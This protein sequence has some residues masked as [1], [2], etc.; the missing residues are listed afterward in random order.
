MA[1]SSRKWKGS[2]SI[3]KDT[4]GGFQEEIGTVHKKDACDG[5]GKS[6]ILYINTM[7][8]YSDNEGIQVCSVCL[9]KI[10]DIMDKELG[11]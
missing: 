7:N 9:R 2:V 4:H 1:F 3:V 10:A 11:K 8:P 5:C 6:G